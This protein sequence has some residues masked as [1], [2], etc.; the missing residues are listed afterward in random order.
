MFR[1]QKARI[2]AIFWVT[3]SF[4]VLCNVNG[5]GV[6]PS[7]ADMWK[8][9]QQQQEEIRALKEKLNMVEKDVA[10]TGEM[11]E[12]VAEQPGG[13]AEGGPSWADK[14]SIGGY[15][16]LHYNELTG[17][18][19][20]SDLNRVDFHRFVLYYGHQ[21]TDRIRFFSEFELEHALTEDTADGSGAGEVELEQA[22]VEMDLGDLQ[23]HA[24][25][26]GVF[27]IPVGILNET[28]EPP[29]FYGTERN[30]V[31]SR[32]IPSTWWEAGLALS[33]EV[34]PG[35]NYDLAYTSGLQVPS[36]YTIRSGRQKVANATAEDGAYSGRLKWSIPGLELAGTV[37]YQTDLTQRSLARDSDGLLLEGH[38]IWELGQFKLKALYAQWDLDSSITGTGSDLD[39][40][41]D[42]QFGWY[43]EPSFK[44]TENIGIFARFSQWDENAGGRVNSSGGSVD[45]EKEQFDIGVNWWPHENVVL[46]LDYQNQYIHSEAGGEQDGFNFGVGYQF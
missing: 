36:S 17:K 29:T 6:V 10:I 24:V 44:I 11:I 43:I 37:H 19:G 41:K 1:D 45:T 12:Q 22:Y 2:V 30:N 13:L 32:I 7:N 35:L 39:N 8:I 42:D 46:K 26:A 20:G 38:V 15:G 14:T 5:Q 34:V 28:H 3:I 40:G 27:L 4:I 16:E 31:E 25:K 33:G 9:I 23:L 18:N 21:F